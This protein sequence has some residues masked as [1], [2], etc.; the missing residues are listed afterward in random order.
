MDPEG[1]M[2]DAIVNANIEILN[3]L[4]LANETSEVCSKALYWTVFKALEYIKKKIGSDA[5]STKAEEYLFM[6]KKIEIVKMILDHGADVNY[7]IYPPQC[8]I[9]SEACSYASA[10]IVQV[11]MNYGADFQLTDSYNFPIQLAFYSGD[12]DKVNLFLDRGIE[13]DAISI[14]WACCTLL[15][16]H[17]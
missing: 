6:S 3:E 1:K 8:S 2:Q 17:Q 10:D 14:V 15:P 11:M 7:F 12:T 13:A 9:F 4:L 16:R 5:E